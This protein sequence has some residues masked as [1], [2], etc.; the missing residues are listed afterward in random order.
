MEVKLWLATCDFRVA[1]YLSEAG[2][3][4]NNEK[5]WLDT[6]VEGVLGIYFTPSQFD[7]NKNTVTSEERRQLEQL[8]KEHT[9]AVRAEADAREGT[10]VLVTADKVNLKQQLELIAKYRAENIEPLKQE[11]IEELIT[12]SDLDFEDRY[13]AQVIEEAIDKVAENVVHLKANT[14]IRGE[15]IT[16]EKTQA[17][18]EQTLVKNQKGRIINTLGVGAKISE[19]VKAKPPQNFSQ[20]SLKYI[21]A[22]QKV[23]PNLH[24]VIGYYKR[25]GLS[26]DQAFTAAHYFD[27]YSQNETVDK[28]FQKAAHEVVGKQFDKMFVK[29]IRQ[30]IDEEVLPPSYVLTSLRTLERYQQDRTFYFTKS[31][32]LHLDSIKTAEG[33]VSI[34]Q[35]QLD[36][37]K[38]RAREGLEFFTRQQ[39]ETAVLG[40]NFLDIVHEQEGARL[41]RKGVVF[42]EAEQRLNQVYQTQLAVIQD[43][44]NTAHRTSHSEL[45]SR[46]YFD[47]SHRTLPAIFLSDAVYE[48]TIWQATDTAASVEASLNNDVVVNIV[49]SEGKKYVSSRLNT[50]KNRFGNSLITKAEQWAVE[51]MA[52]KGLKGLA[53]KGLSKLIGASIPV[54]NA[55]VAVDTALELAEKLPVV[56]IIARPIKGLWDG[57]K[58][59]ALVLGGTAIAGVATL[60]T[61]LISK[62]VG[63]VVSGGIGAI[64]G[65]VVGGIIGSSF[66][67][68]GTVAGIGI[69]STIGTKASLWFS[70]SGGFSGLATKAS[71]ATSSVLSAG[72]GV[73]VIAAPIIAISAVAATTMLINSSL[74][75][76]FSLPP[77][78]QLTEYYQNLPYTSL[79]CEDSNG[80]PI[81]IPAGFANGFPLQEGQV[82]AGTFMHTG[83]SVHTNAIDIAVKP[84][85]EV[86]ATHDGVVRF[87]GIQGSLTTGYG[88]VVF[89][90][91]SAEGKAFETR[92]AHLLSIE[93]GIVSGAAVK[94]GKRI[95][96]VGSTGNSSGPHIHYELV[97][98]QYFSKI[99]IACTLPISNDARNRI[100]NGQKTG[101]GCLGATQ[102][103]IDL[104][105]DI[106]SN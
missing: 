97:A 58:K 34:D 102:C 35:I 44:R 29:N 93:E 105:K 70:N 92:Y 11:I 88:R 5:V 26:S 82:T 46:D 66:G 4:P 2:I 103:N 100:M 79:S 91:G 17:V 65:G 67:P 27:K 32:K 68:W 36:L 47:P 53:A 59:A 40:Q 22:N 64:A 85:T 57:L 14:V 83:R 104:T 96:L 19:Y 80:N 21:D 86:F 55:I 48:E 76:A 38:E 23:A 39:V 18:I 45:F 15:E 50:F 78:D 20:S 81:E 63:V 74:M 49:S 33:N 7:E 3:D 84:G 87:A 73:V 41:T 98:D 69:G 101:T 12:N 42:S 31:G 94:R 51:N 37:N 28:A 95:G 52:K 72:G 62:F 24:T 56:G 8:Y 71:S 77:F 61:F 1:G 30:G 16:P 90:Q 89:L 10:G 25:C 13:K 6:L 54:L 9:E 99:N 60:A 106:I 43:I 75:A